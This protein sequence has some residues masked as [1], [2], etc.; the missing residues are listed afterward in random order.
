MAYGAPVEGLSLV[1]A[2]WCRYCCGT[3]DSGEAIASND[4][5]WDRLQERALAAKDRPEAWLEMRHIYGDLGAE[6]RF[7]EAF[8]RWLRLIHAEGMEAALK[9]YTG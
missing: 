6:P 4:P 1:S 8:A 9:A 5:D 7:A 2:A 3:T